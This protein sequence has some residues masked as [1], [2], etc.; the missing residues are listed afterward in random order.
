M[1]RRNAARGFAQF[2]A[3][4]R[5]GR[6]SFPNCKD[7]DDSIA[8]G[9]QGTT[10]DRVKVAIM[11]SSCITEMNL[12]RNAPRRQTRLP[13]LFLFESCPHIPRQGNSELNACQHKFSH[14]PAP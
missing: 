6:G 13:R 1:F 8:A 7:L 14:D 9:P 3:R 12:D 11:A 4:L 5:E 10:V 2:F